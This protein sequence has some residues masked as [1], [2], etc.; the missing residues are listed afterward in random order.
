MAKQA[1]AFSTDQELPLDVL[2]QKTAWLGISG[3]GKTYSL[4]GLVEKLIDAGGQVVIVDTVGNWYGLRLSADGQK[5][6]RFTFPVVGGDRGD[7]PLKA[8]SGKLIAGAVVSTGSS[9]ILDVSDLVDEELVSFVG[10]FA[11]E[12]LRLKK[13]SPGPLL[14]VWEECQDI[15][16]QTFSKGDNAEMAKAVTRLIKRGRNYGV[17]TALVS[18]RAA[19]VNKEALNQVETVFAFRTI[20]PQDRDAI[21]RWVGAHA[22]ETRGIDLASDLASLPTGTCFVWSP[23]WLRVY[24][25]VKAGRKTTFDASKTPDLDRANVAAARLAP[26]D[27]EALKGQLGK[28]IEEADAQD[29]AKL[30]RRV[31]ELERQLAAKPA[32]AATVIERPMLREEDRRKLEAAIAGMEAMLVPIRGAADKVAVAA[33]QLEVGLRAAAGLRSQATIGVI[34]VPRASVEINETTRQV[35]A[36]RKATRD[37]RPAVASGRGAGEL[38]KGETAV[39]TAIAQ[40]DDGCSREQLTVLTGYRRSSRDT[41]LQRLRAAGAIREERDRFVITEA[42]IKQLGDFVPLPTGAALREHWLRE[43]TGGERAIFEI[44]IKG[45]GE[46]VDREELSRVTGYQR[47][48]R[49]TFIQRLAARELVIADRSGVRASEELF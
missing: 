49:D 40:Y 16:P 13:R 44:V 11:T 22:G 47:S 29:P 33:Q 38:G 19:A 23:A 27:V 30:Q 39:L 12:L 1:I 32:A 42:G 35:V 17:G 45:C 9:F 26:V 37:S 15:V 36:A 34:S 3:S 10:A 31:R 24:K 2:S 14:V 20:G 28:L 46:P 8:S 4:G 6:S 21:E 41:F 18:Q 25:R 5:P 48:S 43:L 7:I